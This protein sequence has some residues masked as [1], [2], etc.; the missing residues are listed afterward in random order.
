MG[1]I[2]KKNKSYGKTSKLKEVEDQNRNL[3]KVP[4]QITAFL[5]EI[6]I[7]SVDTKTC[8]SIHSREQ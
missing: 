3:A 7:T 6:E 1:S 4:Y 8:W 2:V 5:N